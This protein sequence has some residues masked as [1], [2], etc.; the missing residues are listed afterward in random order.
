MTVPQQKTRPAQ[1]AN[2]RGDL[3][4]PGPEGSPS[5]AETSPAQRKSP[6]WVSRALCFSD[7]G[8]QDC[9]LWKS[10]QGRISMPV[11]G[12]SQEWYCRFSIRNVMARQFQKINV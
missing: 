8:T 3:V 2:K 5:T 6:Q 10:H 12:R 9:M 4:G 1:R 11:Y 7:G